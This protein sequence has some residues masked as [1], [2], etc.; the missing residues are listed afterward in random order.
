MS[1]EGGGNRGGSN[2]AEAIAKCPLSDK[3]SLG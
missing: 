2:E 3:I 1:A